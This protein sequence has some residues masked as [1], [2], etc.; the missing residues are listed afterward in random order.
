[1]RD[2]FSHMTNMIKPCVRCG[3]CCKEEVCDIGRILFETD[4]PPCPALIP[5]GDKMA[6]G[7][8]VHGDII[9]EGLSVLATLALGIGKGCDSQFINETP[10]VK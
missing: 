4:T 9:N 7:V 8:V 10:E 2:Q 3:R 1:M 6:C 5:D